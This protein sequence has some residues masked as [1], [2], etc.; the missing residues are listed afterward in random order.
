M[1]LNNIRIILIETSHPGNIGSAARAM[2]TMG[3]SHLY[4]VKPRYFPD[5][6]A[7]VM[8]SG[9]TDILEQ[10]TVVE[11][12]QDAVEGCHMVIGTS[13]RL[14]RYIRWPIMSSR[15]CGTWVSQFQ[16]EHSNAS[17]ALVFGRERT[18]LT[19]EELEYCHRLVN[20]PVNPDYSSLNVASAVQVMSYELSMGAS[21]FQAT[22]QE[23]ASSTRRTDELVSAGEMEGFY[24]HMEEVLI[25]VNYL[26]PAKP[27]L[28][29][30]RLRK[31]YGRIQ[32]TR[33]ELNIL[34]GMMSAC[35][36]S[37]FIPREDKK[38]E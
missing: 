32:L 27:R 1:S 38:S 4:L 22:V 2:K 20:I 19:N 9:A 17:V 5:E 15:E 37:K 35:A 14:K 23:M 24:Q 12:L 36:G 13:A 21:Q 7:T 33:S 28:L 34:R 16:S 25:K 10:A 26:D 18:G 3:L 31:L 29:M 30:R 11:T 6:K 8:S